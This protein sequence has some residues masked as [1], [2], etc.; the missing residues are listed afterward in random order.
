MSDLVPLV[1]AS[2]YTELSLKEELE[3]RRVLAGDDS[4]MDDEQRITKA[5]WCVVMLWRASSHS[6]KESL[7][8]K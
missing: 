5:F 6:Y 2:K 1:S 8:N 3:R 4:A 7:P